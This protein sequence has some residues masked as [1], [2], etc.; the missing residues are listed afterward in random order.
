[1]FCTPDLRLSRS[2]ATVTVKLLHT[3]INCL[4]Y[5][6]ATARSSRSAVSPRLLAYFIA[7][8]EI[9]RSFVTVH[10]FVSVVAI[11]NYRL[12][13]TYQPPVPAYSHRRSGLRG[14]DSHLA[15]ALNAFFRRPHLALNMRRECG[16]FSPSAV[17][18][19][20][21]TLFIAI[22]LSASSPPYIF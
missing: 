16:L 10:R 2:T 21:L 1:M 8:R 19:F 7:A 3:D 6:L 11:A 22:N 18:L 9:P 17:A 20:S 5:V 13:R 14:A 15:F 4:N 12:D